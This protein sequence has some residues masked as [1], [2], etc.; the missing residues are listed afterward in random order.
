LV[1]VLDLAGSHRLDPVGVLWGLGA[2][3]GLA[4][5][6]L[7]S[8]SADEPLPPLVMAWG[9]MCIGAVA[10]ITLGICG[11]LPMRTPRT[12]VHLLDHRVSWLVPVI[13]L[14]LIAAV[15]AYVAGIGAARLLGAK[16]ASFV[17]LT[18]VV[19][20][21]VFAWLLLGQVPTEVQF[22]GGVLILTGV[23]LVHIDELRESA[24]ATRARHHSSLP[25]ARSDRQ[26]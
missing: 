15:I 12:D 18:E 3:I 25:L 8:A 19:F 2:A 22:G 20:A 9:G 13:G 14:S 26:S 24:R 21:V 17:G 10:L 4:V 1:L 6:F 7:L 23:A 5:Y 16:L 11:L